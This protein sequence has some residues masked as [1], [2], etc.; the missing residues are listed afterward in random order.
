MRDKGDPVILL[1]R[2]A[3]GQMSS[4]SYFGRLSH[5]NTGEVR[6]TPA[7]GIIEL[8]KADHS[9]YRGIL[10]IEGRAGNIIVSGGAKQAIMVA[11]QALL[12]PQ[13]ELLFPSRMG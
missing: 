8:K 3:K 5:L 2:R 9:I 4:E 12:N 6:Y 11:L 10:P 7:D 13:E 1:G